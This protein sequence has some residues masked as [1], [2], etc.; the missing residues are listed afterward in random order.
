[1]RYIP[2]DAAEVV[3]DIRQ[4]ED[5]AVEGYDE[6]V[7]FQR[8]A[9]VGEVLVIQICRVAVGVQHAYERDDAALRG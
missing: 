6:V 3:F 5:R 8:L 1:M 4:V 9:E 2:E 7:P